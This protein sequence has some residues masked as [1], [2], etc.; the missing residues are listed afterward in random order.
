M[1]NVIVKE[2][3]IHEKG[4]FASRNFKKG[5]V[6]LKWDISHELTKKEVDSMPEEEK[7]YVTFF[8]GKYV[9]MQPPERYVNHSCEANTHAENFCDVAKRDIM[10]GEEITADYAEEGVPDMNMKCKCGSKN[11]RGIIKTDS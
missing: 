1:V 5:E 4:V 11:C 8:D 3:K 9:L 6:V 7:R 10:E 2:S